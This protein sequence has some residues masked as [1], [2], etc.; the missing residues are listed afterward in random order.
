M[1]H[2]LDTR[3]YEVSGSTACCVENSAY[4]VGGHLRGH[5][6]METFLQVECMNLTT[7][8][9]KSQYHNTNGILNRSFHCSCLI[10]KEIFVFGGTSAESDA[11]DQ[12]IHEVIRI[13]MTEYGLVSTTF[14][15]DDE[16]AVSLQGQSVC[17]MGKLKKYVLLYGGMS[18]VR[19]ETHHTAVRVYRSNL[20]SFSAAHVEHPFGHVDVAFEDEVPP[21]RA[22]HTAVVC[23]DD[24]EF[25]IVCGGRN[26]E[27]I[28]NDIWLLDMSSVLL[29]QEIINGS[30]KDKKASESVKEVI[31]A[32]AKRKGTQPMIPTARWSRIKF[33]D[34]SIFLPRQLHSS[35]FI[36][37]KKSET[38]TQCFGTF[39]V[40]GGV[41]KTGILSSKIEEFNFDFLERGAAL[42][43]KV[44]DHD[45][46]EIAANVSLSGYGSTTAAYYGPLDF[47]HNLPQ[48][49]LIFGG[50]YS[51]NENR[52]SSYCKAIIFDD[53]NNILKQVI[54]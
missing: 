6:G 26:G 16:S 7:L 17:L 15:V 40:F 51:F 38:A 19:D 28:L 50:S 42:S 5:V 22:F 43:K 18:F 33:Q 31:P 46:M 2:N 52:I 27:S 35:Y 21:G 20:S 10:D 34:D 23:G 25:M 29:N 32:S 39:H 14:C 44:K 4:I 48:A 45:N 41:G 3:D 9:W 13:S 49:L 47:R 30:S 12:N 37:N 11:L 53:E 54:F 36:P 24:N 1:I 8:A